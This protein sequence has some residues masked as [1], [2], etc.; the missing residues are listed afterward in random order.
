MWELVKIR[1]GETQA[2]L[3]A[4]WEPFAVISDPH[5]NSSMNTLY[6]QI[7]IYLRKKK[8]VKLGKV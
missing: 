3:D 4:G 1:E 2:Y 7:Y 5:W 6:T 8:G